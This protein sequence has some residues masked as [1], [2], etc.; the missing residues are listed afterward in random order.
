MVRSHSYTIDANQACYTFYSG[1]FRHKICRRK[2]IEEK[3]TAGRKLLPPE[4]FKLQISFEGLKMELIFF[5]WVIH[6][7]MGQAKV[8]R[9]SRGCKGNAHRRKMSKNCRTF[10]H[11]H[12]LKFEHA[13]WNNIHKQRSMLRNTKYIDMRTHCFVVCCVSAVEVNAPVSL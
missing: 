11:Q 6:K 1:P 10:K 8:L 2:F 9:F 4:I 7:Y 3:L 12:V 5:F 13:T